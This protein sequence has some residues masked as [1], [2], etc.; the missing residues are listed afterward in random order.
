[1]I[2]GD[3]ADLTVADRTYTRVVQPRDSIGCDSG[4][5]YPI[6]IR[7]STQL[8]RSHGRRE[9][10]DPGYSHINLGWTY[11]PQN[12]NPRQPAHASVCFLEYSGSLIP[13]VASDTHVSTTAP[14]MLLNYLVLQG[15]V[16]E[17]NLLHEGAFVHGFKWAC[18]FA[19]FYK[20]CRDPFKMLFYTSLRSYCCVNGM[21]F[22]AYVKSDF[23]EIIGFLYLMRPPA[24]IEN[25]RRYHHGPF[26]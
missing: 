18:P 19:I 13:H 8:T 9:S 6:C 16:W 22:R 11:S 17:W 3:I 12:E 5:F 24:R 20:L 21:Y 23:S 7:L 4:K 25:T 26:R 10:A 2:G 15:Q 1:M 14:F